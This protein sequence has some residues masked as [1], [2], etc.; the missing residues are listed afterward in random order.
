MYMLRLKVQGAGFS[1]WGDDQQ[2]PTKAKADRAL[3]SRQPERGC[4][5]AL[6]LP[7]SRS[8]ARFVLRARRGRREFTWRA[9]QPTAN[10]RTT[11]TRRGDARS[12]TCPRNGRAY[13]RAS[14][15]IGVL[16]GPAQPA[17]STSRAL[18]RGSILW[19]RAIPLVTRSREASCC[20]SSAS[21]VEGR[22][23]ERE[24]WPRRTNRLVGRFSR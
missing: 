20:R 4:S 17:F 23:E 12:P 19:D 6:Q 7:P 14:F 13:R 18:S 10:R 11:T 8:R 24:P 15:A 9:F 3:E 5:P 2:G 21:S 1:E 22:D 16:R